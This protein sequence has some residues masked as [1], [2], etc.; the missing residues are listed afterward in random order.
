MGGRLIR[1]TRFSFLCPS[2]VATVTPAVAPHSSTSQPADSAGWRAAH[3]AY[4]A[5]PRAPRRGRRPGRSCGC[6]AACARGPPRC[7]AA[8]AAYRAPSGR[9]RG[10]QKRWARRIAAR[11]ARAARPQR[12]GRG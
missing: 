2:T 10:R 11:A 7:T 6:G 4:L 3:P 9:S 5:P 1:G 8:R 12:A